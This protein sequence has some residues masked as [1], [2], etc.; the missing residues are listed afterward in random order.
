MS[1]AAKFVKSCIP[2]T[3]LILKISNIFISW[4]NPFKSSVKSSC[5]VKV[6]IKYFSTVLHPHLKGFTSGMKGGDAL[7]NVHGALHSTSYFYFSFT[8]HWGGGGVP[9]FWIQLHVR[10]TSFALARRKAILFTA[11]SA[12]AKCS[13]TSFIIF[14]KIVHCTECRF[15]FNAIKQV[16][17]LN[18]KEIPKSRTVEVFPLNDIFF[19]VML[20]YRYRTREYWM[21]IR[22][23]GEDS[24]KNIKQNNSWHC[25]F[26]PDSNCL[27]FEVE[28]DQ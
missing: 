23:L 22:G 13:C 14:K 28:T 5:K 25:P 6:F 10:K 27:D 16:R 2:K 7:C 18:M 24:W 21:I 19:F 15:L 20:S 9:L 4:H 8:G 11:L 12:I 17:V 1:K 3:D 26:Y